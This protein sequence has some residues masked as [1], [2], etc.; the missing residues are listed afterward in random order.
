[1]QAEL[2]PAELLDNLVTHF[3][4]DPLALVMALLGALF[5]GGASAVFGYL[6]LGAALDLI[7]PDVSNQSPPRASE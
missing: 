4:G 5:V 3:T 1:M 2:S 6:S 7:M